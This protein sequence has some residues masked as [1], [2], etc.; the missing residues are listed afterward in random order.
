M[1]S[2][3]HLNLE[4]GTQLITAKR[5]KAY[6]T[7]CTLLFPSLPS[8]LKYL[9]SPFPITVFHEFL[10]SDENRSVLVRVRS[11]MIIVAASGLP[12]HPFPFWYGIRL[13]FYPLYELVSSAVPP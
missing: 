11:P 10:V 8:V 9:H 6:F 7:L 3:F 5:S 2:L 4:V 13:H 12:Y 1:S